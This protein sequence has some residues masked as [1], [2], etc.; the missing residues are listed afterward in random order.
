MSMFDRNVKI[1]FNKMKYSDLVAKNAS[2]TLF[3]TSYSYIVRARTSYF[4]FGI[5]TAYN[6]LNY[7]VFKYKATRGLDRWMKRL[8]TSFGLNSHADHGHEHGNDHGHGSE[9][10][11]DNHHSGSHESNNHKEHDHHHKIVESTH[12]HDNNHSNVSHDTNLSHSDNS[13]NTINSNDN[14]DNKSNHH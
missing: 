5:I 2:P 1:Q 6:L 13:N 9:H 14:H 12:T 3:S 7:D 11:H 10:K 8:K 4:L